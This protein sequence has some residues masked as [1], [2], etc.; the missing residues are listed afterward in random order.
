MLSGGSA[1]SASQHPTSCAVT[2]CMPPWTRGVRRHVPQRGH[3]SEG[4]VGTL[5]RHPFLHF[6]WERLHQVFLEAVC[7][8][9]W[10]IFGFILV[11][12]AIDEIICVWTVTPSCMGVVAV[13]RVLRRC[14]ATVWVFTWFVIAL[15]ALNSVGSSA[16]RAR[17]SSHRKIWLASRHV[18]SLRARWHRMSSKL[19]FARHGD[20]VVRARQL[21][22]SEQRDQNDSVP[23]RRM[24][25]HSHQ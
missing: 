1:V 10:S 19:I 7:C 9:S 12:G 24:K 15:R 11:L 4:G 22:R 23:A 13:R 6:G 8:E 17:C 18:G 16:V 3:V 20:D 25:S 14:F 2:R 5:S 21:K